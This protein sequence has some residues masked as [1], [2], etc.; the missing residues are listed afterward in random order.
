MYSK[1]RKYEEITDRVE[2]EIAHYL[3]KVSQGEMSNEASARV[4][5]MLSITN[6]LERIGDIFYQMS[7]TIERKEE[8]KVWFSQEQRDNLK[9]MLH[10]IDD[11]FAIMNTNLEASYGHISMESALE[12]EREINK[13]RNKLRSQHYER[14]G[15]KDHSIKNGM[16][17]ND[18][19]SSCEKIGD[20]IINVSEAVAGEI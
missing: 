13:F 15:D 5:S 14:L 9:Q 3:E 10:L 19:F 2:V 1:I 18:L 7:K 8:E 12:K 11:A 20:H 6:D 4:R 16:I 17:Y